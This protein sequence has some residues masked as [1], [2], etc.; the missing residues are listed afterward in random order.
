MI[1]I[2]QGKLFLCEAAG[3][4][5]ELLNLPSFEENPVDLYFPEDPNYTFIKQFVSPGEF[6]ATM[7]VTKEQYFRMIDT[8][9]GLFKMIC[10]LCPNKKVVYLAMYGKK[11]RT[12]KKNRQRAIRILEKEARHHG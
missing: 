1:N 9:T 4:E 3:T 7:K 12:R 8:F 6:S 10:E 2:K 11:R 5:V